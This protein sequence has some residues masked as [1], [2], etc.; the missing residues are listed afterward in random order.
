MICMTARLFN[1]G[2]LFSCH[3]GE[4]GSVNHDVGKKG[5]G[6]EEITYQFIMT[7]P[8]GTPIDQTGI[9]SS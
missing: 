4:D 3:M 7:N 6:A 1:T 8:D 5:S 2:Y 9:L